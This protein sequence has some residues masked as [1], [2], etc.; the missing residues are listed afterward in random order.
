MI[1]AITGTPC[2]GKTTT[3][4]EI[5]KH[6]NYTYIDI[7]KI[8][9]ENNLCEGYDDVRECNIV[10]PEKLNKALEPILKKDNLVIDSH[11]SHEIPKEKIDLCIVTKCDIKELEK[12]LKKRNYKPEKIRENMDAEIFE[13]CYIEA[14][15]KGHNLLILE[16][17]KPISWQELDK[18]FK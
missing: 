8:I 10:D 13:I 1:V 5:A 16:T 6:Y 12:R 3:A 17:D 7:N 15:E 9:E 18:R 4:K 14:H 2:T 11:L